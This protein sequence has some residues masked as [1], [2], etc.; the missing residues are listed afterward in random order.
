MGRNSQGNGLG[1]VCSY[2]YLIMYIYTYVYCDAPIVR[3]IRV[4]RLEIAIS[5]AAQEYL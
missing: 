2:F 4:V 1:Q 3:K 5:Q